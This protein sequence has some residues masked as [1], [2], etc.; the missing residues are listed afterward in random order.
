MK[1]VSLILIL[2][3]SF[4]C[5]ADLR[6][7]DMSI[8]LSSERNTYQRDEVIQFDIT[9]TN[10]T[11][12][13]NGVLLPGTKNKGKRMIFLSYYSVDST[14]FYTNVFTE[15]RVI[16]MDTS[17]L[18]QTGWANLDPGESITIPIFFGDT[19]N[20][21]THNA[22]HHKI[23]DLPAGNY[24]VLAWYDP[25]DEPMAQYAFKQINPFGRSDDLLLPNRNGNQL[26]FALQTVTFATQ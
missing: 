13:Q 14:N 20:Y 6:P 25:W 21:S 22:A 17:A 2:L 7:P 18:G 4:S 5:L 11:T 8:H 12:H 15:S 1:T 19:K 24:Q 23:P 9:F 3:S 10:L 26:S 16:E